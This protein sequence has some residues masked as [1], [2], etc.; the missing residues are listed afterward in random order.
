M[1]YMYWPLEN[2]LIKVTTEIRKKIKQVGLCIVTLVL[3]VV[4]SCAL[5]Y[6]PGPGWRG[7]LG[8]EDSG[9]EWAIQPQREKQLQLPVPCSMR[10]VWWRGHTRCSERWLPWEKSPTKPGKWRN[11]LPPGGNNGSAWS[12]SLARALWSHGI[13]L[14]S[15]TRESLDRSR[16]SSCSTFCSSLFVVVPSLGCVQ[17]FV[18]QWT[19]VPRLPC[20]SPSPGVCSSSCPLSWWCSSLS[21]FLLYHW[22]LKSS[23][24]NGGTA[25]LGHPWHLVHGPG[26]WVMSA[27]LQPYLRY[28]G[29]SVQHGA[30]LQVSRCWIHLF[31]NCSIDLGL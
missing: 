10:L 11:S 21:E 26:R 9:G 18:T 1:L 25:D 23:A 6:T 27:W 28:S 7:G 13:I 15:I 24:T 16:G 17:L 14:V 30:P 12:L 2:K 20:P 31:I 5:F 29:T 22:W 3:T 19:A 4:W 8:L